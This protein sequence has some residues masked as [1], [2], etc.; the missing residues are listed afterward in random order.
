MKS[1]PGRAR[2]LNGDSVRKVVGLSLVIGAVWALALSSSASA[3]PVTIGSPLTG[4]FKSNIC[5]SEPCTL[6]QGE[7][8]GATLTAPITGTIIRWRMIDGASTFHY[9]LRVIGGSGPTYTGA[10]TSAAATPAGAGIETFP[11]DL[12]IQAGQRV[13]IDLEAQAPLGEKTTAGA[14]YLYFAPPLAD[15]ATSISGG[16]SAEL[17]FNADILPPPSIASISYPAHSASVLGG[18][19]VTIAGANFVEVKGVS[20]GATPASSYAVSSEGTITAVAP[21][22]ATLARVPLS[23]TTVAGSA[24][25]T[26]TF[27]YKGCLV[28]KL[29]GKKLKTAKKKLKAADCKVGTV[30]KL[31]GATSKTGKVKKQSPKPGKVLAPGSKVSVKLGD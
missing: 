20:F 31:K 30:R 21:P 5:V 6:A 14:T 11:T 12:P 25:S 23:V 2:Q 29:K 13:G 27:V 1:V 26:Q 24:S 17:G 3:S 10:G 7:L 22:S 16:G 28:P 8:P 19:T 18:G 15:G 4:S 9:K